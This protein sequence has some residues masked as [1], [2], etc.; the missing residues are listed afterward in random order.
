MKRIILLTVLVVVVAVETGLAQC[1]T[2][3]PGSPKEILQELWSMA[4]RGDLLNDS[5]WAKASK[6]FFTEATAGPSNK[7][8]AVISNQWG[9]PTERM[10]STDTAEVDVGFWDRGQVDSSLRYIPSNP[11]DA[12]KM[13]RSYRLILVPAYVMMYGSDGKTLLQKRP[14]GC[15]QW[16]IKG[17]MEQ[18][19]TTVN[20]AIR[21]VLER[22]NKTEDAKIKENADATLSKLMTLH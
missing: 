14:T 5:G 15:Q 22:R 16:E 17:S 2:G 20:T 1:S 8:I 4:T 3:S 9:P 19:W 18:P 7:S 21:Y 11:T 10:L 6:S 13:G 12:I